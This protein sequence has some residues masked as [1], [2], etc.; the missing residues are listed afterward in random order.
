MF[1][2][3]VDIM[4]LTLFG[5]KPLIVFNLALTVLLNLAKP[6]Q[7]RFLI[8]MTKHEFGKHRL[9]DRTCLVNNQNTVRWPH[10]SWSPCSWTDLAQT[11]GRLAC[12]SS[13]IAF[14][15]I[16][17]RNILGFPTPWIDDS[18]ELATGQSTNWNSW[19]ESWWVVHCFNTP[20]NKWIVPLPREFTNLASYPVSSFKPTTMITANTLLQLQ[21]DFH[22]GHNTRVK[23]LEATILTFKLTQTWPILYSS[24]ELYNL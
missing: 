11:G 14:C 18:C 10:S 2:V 7:G 16:L 6:W 13:T 21:A 12:S 22:G 3:D 20:K 4:E 19:M 5:T 9:E 23:G 15:A 1:P 24:I 17:C 8:V